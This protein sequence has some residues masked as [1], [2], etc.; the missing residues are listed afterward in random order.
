VL[1]ESGKGVWIRRDDWMMKDIASRY[2]NMGAGFPVF[3]P[4]C[5]YIF[6]SVA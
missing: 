2:C 1:N 6:C 4:P 5:A 3:G